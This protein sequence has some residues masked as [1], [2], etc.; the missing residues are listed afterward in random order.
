M[1]MI[2]PIEPILHPVAIGDL[3]PTQMTVGMYEVKRKRADWRDRRNEEGG[4]FLGEHLIPA[5]TGPNNSYWIV[6]HHHL[7]RA[8]HEEGVEKV[9][10]TVIAKLDHLPGR[11]FYAFLDRHNW[12]HPYNEDGHRCDWK[13]IPRHIGKLADDPYRSL[14]GEVRRAGGFAK[15]PTPYTEFLWADFFR[16][17]IKRKLI[18]DKFGKALIKALSLARTHDAG[19]LPG[20]AG[21]E[22][23]AAARDDSE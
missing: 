7:A 17:R 16:D 2:N 13:D 5:V 23:G 6:D 8:L 9:L 14:A 15:M 22:R 3:R 20:F 4:Q 12:L 1:A 18:E 10:V 19:Y 11:R 21:P